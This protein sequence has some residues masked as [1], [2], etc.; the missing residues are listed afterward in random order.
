MLF[1]FLTYLCPNGYAESPY[2]FTDSGLSQTLENRSGSPSAVSTRTT[3][4]VTKM[5]LFVGRSIFRNL[6][7]YPII[8]LVLK[9]F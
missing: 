2:F 6:T 3:D 1:I 8:S 9:T 4:S 5:V 7:L